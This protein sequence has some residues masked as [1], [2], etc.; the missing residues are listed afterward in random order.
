MIKKA[1]LGCF[2]NGVNLIGVRLEWPRFPLFRHTKNSEF[3]I[4]QGVEVRVW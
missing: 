3:V 4:Y 1:S 2:F